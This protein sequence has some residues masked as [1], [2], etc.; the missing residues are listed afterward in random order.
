MG[1][2]KRVWQP[3]I[4]DKEYT[5]ELS[6]SYWSGKREIRL[7][8]NLI[9]KGQR[10][11]DV[12]SKHT[13][14]ICGVKCTLRITDGLFGF[15]YG[16]RVANK[17]VLPAQEYGDCEKIDWVF[18]PQT[19]SDY[20]AQV[21]YILGWIAY[22]TLVIQLVLSFACSI[23]GLVMFHFAV[24]YAIPALIG[25]PIGIIALFLPSD[26]MKERNRRAIKGIGFGSF[27]I[28]WQAFVWIYLI[29]R[30]ARVF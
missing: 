29:P 18:S 9:Y 20:L 22:V 12:G 16:L 15:K 17:L 19:L 3:R 30:I 13:F 6:H 8:G 14:D 23:A 24:V 28:I 1:I 10:L 11:F 25:V 5:V 2:R 26:Q 27:G 21:S 4:A 7:D